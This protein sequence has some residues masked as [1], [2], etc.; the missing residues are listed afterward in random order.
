MLKNTTTVVLALILWCAY[1]PGASAVSIGFSPSASVGVTS[2]GSYSWD[3]I[4]SDLGVGGI[5]AAYDLDILYNTAILLPTTVDFGL[6]LG[7]ATQ[8]I[9]PGTFE[10]YQGSAVQPGGVIDIAALS[11]WSDLDLQARQSSAG[12][13]IILATL[14]FNALT[15][16]ATSLGFSWG[17][18]QDIKGAGNTPIYPPAAVPEPG[19]ILLLG[20]GL[21][22][23]LP[24]RRRI[25]RRS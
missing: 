25:S 17:P 7:N 23:L 1:A 9:V 18:G 20:S 10:V 5:V 22:A 24:F 19:T 16:G 4:V 3:I 14:N 13:S 12:G 2:G 21:A 8:Q 11:M 6:W 15:D